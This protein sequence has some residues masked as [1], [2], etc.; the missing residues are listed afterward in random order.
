[1]TDI[2]DQTQFL[3]YFVH[4]FELF[5]FI[6]N[7]QRHILSLSLFY[8]EMRMK[9]NLYYL[10]E[11]KLV[12]QYHECIHN[13]IWNNP[14]PCCFSPPTPCHALT[15]KIIRASTTCT[16]HAFS[17]TLQS[18]LPSVELNQHVLAWQVPPPPPSHLYLKDNLD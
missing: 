12:H 8:F 3:G 17:L 5:F 18:G 2:L 1:M 15:V 16:V 9:K 11:I 4:N 7:L 13:Y 6:N 14:P 10:R